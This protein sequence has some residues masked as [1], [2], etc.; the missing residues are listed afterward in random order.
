MKLNDVILDKDRIWFTSDSHFSHTN[1]IKYCER[2]FDNTFQMN[3]ELIEKWNQTVRPGDTVF[4]LGDVSLGTKSAELEEIIG[5]LNGHVYLIRGNH[6]K[7]ALRKEAMRNI[8]KGIFDILEIFIPDDEITYEEQHIVLC[9]YP[10]L[11]W[12]GS[13]RGSWNLFGH[14]HGTLDDNPVLKPT[15]LDVGV[16]SHG[17]YPISYQQVKELITKQHLK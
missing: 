5:N 3:K 13:H 17:Y 4:H 16:D 8:W 1:I 2:P 12:S 15:Q 10:M 6:E 9:H 11:A 7:D 14:V